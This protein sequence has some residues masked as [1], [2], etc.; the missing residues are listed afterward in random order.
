MTVVY[1]IILSCGG[2]GFLAWHNVECM[3]LRDVSRMLHYDTKKRVVDKR[4]SLTRQEAGTDS[5][6]QGAVERP[7]RS[8]YLVYLT[9]GTFLFFVTAVATA[10]FIRYAGIDRTV[11]PEKITIATQGASA[12]DGGAAVPLTIRV[13]NRNSVAVEGATLYITYP[14]GVYIWEDDA[15]VPLQNKDKEL[16]L[17]DIQR[18]EILNRHIMPV[19]YG[20]SGA[21]KEI[22]YLLEYTIPGVSKRQTRRS[23]HEVLLR[24]APVLVSEPEYSSVVAGKEVTFTFD[25]QSNASAVLPMVYVDL[26][27]PVGFIPKRFSPTPVNVGGT[28][29]RFPG[30]Q[31][32]VKKTITVTGTIRGEGQALQS[33]SARARV[34]PSGEQFAD[35]I[36]VSSEEDVVD[37]GEA[38]LAVQVRLNGKVSDRI[39]VSPGDVV[40]GDV[41][42]VNQDSSQL[43]DLV[44]I[45]TIVGTGLDESSITPEDDGYFDEVRREI[46]WDKEGDRSFSSV[47]VGDGGAVSFSFR[48][49]PDLAEFVQ[50]QKYVQV[51]VSAQARRVS[52]D[53]IERIEDVAVGRADV[54]S[55]LYVVGSTLHT[56]SVVR[57]SGPFPPQA[58]KETT[59]ALKYFLKNSGND[60]SQVTLS[61]SLG[62]GVALTDVTSG[63]SLSEW[64]YDADQHLVMVRIPQLTASGPRSSRS[65]EFQ[66]AVKPQRQDVGQHL[67]LAR[68]AE[69]SARDVY[70]DEVF[71]G[72][73]GQL[74]TEITAEPAENTRVVEY[75]QEIEEGDRIDMIDIISPE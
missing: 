6:W 4:A 51:R 20:E 31:P 64:E 16:F 13:G 42:W 60:V 62:R 67:V 65:V 40:R 41:R 70:V 66:V 68:R 71:E 61:V 57:N 74:T 52:T 37:V 18:G 22:T 30:L 34:A 32:G 44:L 35:A 53:A 72:Q 63:V 43:R 47:R 10:Y 33:I 39:I 1:G 9:I 2:I 26:R 8:R 19:F 7:A 54:R 11:S 5:Q 15:V 3:R 46:V 24:T 29:W 21:V 56:T 14:K 45:A 73:V 75:R 17:G 50:S 38:F 58:G 27:Y 59:Y 49:L 25:V 69:Y 28:E 55:V 48:A 12:V 36:V 23:S